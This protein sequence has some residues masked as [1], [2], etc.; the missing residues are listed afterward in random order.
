MNQLLT[1]GVRHELVLADE[2]HWEIAAGDEAA[3]AMVAQLGRAMQLRLTA[4]ATRS[5]PQGTLRRL[6]VQVDDHASGADCHAPLAPR[7]DGSVACILRRCEQGGGPFANLVR[8]S[9]VFAREAQ[10]RGGVLLHGALAERDGRGV[11]LAAP[12]GTGKTTASNRLPVPWRSLCDDTTLVVRDPH[13]NYW[14][15][16]WPTWSRFLDGG[17]GGTWDT[18]SAVPLKGI[19]FLA[20]AVDDRVERLGPGHAVSLLVECVK[21]AAR[22]MPLGP[23]KEELRALQLEWFNNLCALARVIPAHVLHISQTGAFWHE[24]E[25]SLPGGHCTE[26]G[27]FVRR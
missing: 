20:R 10:A 8:L 25:Q 26:I 5:H 3:A 4:G 18:Q 17:A 15:H 21:Q 11:I 23:P 19:F 24:I 7:R 14:A 1:P 2:S 9:L 6:L 27:L 13:G 16:P 12:G 22:F